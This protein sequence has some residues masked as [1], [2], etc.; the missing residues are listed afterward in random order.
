MT[1]RCFRMAD[2]LTVVDVQGEAAK[3]AVV[4]HGYGLL[5]EIDCGTGT[6]TAQADPGYVAQGERE[7]ALLD[8]L[9]PAEVR[10]L[11]RQIGS[12]QLASLTPAAVVPWEKR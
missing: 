4:A 6:I 2:H 1:E 11:R 7:A 3:D 5:A 9:E 8:E 10:Q 12:A